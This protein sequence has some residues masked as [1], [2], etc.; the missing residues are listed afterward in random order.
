MRH[1]AILAY[2][3]QCSKCQSWA[4]WLLSQLPPKLCQPLPLKDPGL[5]SR[6]PY[7]LPPYVSEQV[8]WIAA[9]GDGFRGGRAVANALKATRK[10]KWLGY[11]LDCWPIRPFT[12]LGYYIV[13]KMIHG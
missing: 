8:I 7:L 3:N 4:T 2:D 5:R 13:A 9:N 11:V 1:L 12:I 6:Y 10:W